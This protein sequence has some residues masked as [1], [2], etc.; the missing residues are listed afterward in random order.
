MRACVRV[1]VTC[2]KREVKVRLAYTVA[3]LRLSDVLRGNAGAWGLCELRCYA[4]MLHNK[5][6]A[7]SCLSSAPIATVR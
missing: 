3:S 5:L 6:K 4:P 2:G 1:R 7:I